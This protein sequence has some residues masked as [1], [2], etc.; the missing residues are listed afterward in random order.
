MMLINFV[1]FSSI[2]NVKPDFYTITNSALNMHGSQKVNLLPILCIFIFRVIRFSQNEVRLLLFLLGQ[3]V[4]W[5]YNPNPL[6][7]NNHVL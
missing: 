2:Y 6:V 7:K 1:A 5:Q 3:I 4:I